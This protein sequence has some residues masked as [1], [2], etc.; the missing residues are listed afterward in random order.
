MDGNNK[1]GMTGLN[2]D[3]IDDYDDDNSQTI[4]AFDWIA[5][6]GQHGG[7]DDGDDDDYEQDE[8][9]LIPSKYS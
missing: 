7:D 5:S 9:D 2:V 3:D 4:D 8:A 1:S 6:G